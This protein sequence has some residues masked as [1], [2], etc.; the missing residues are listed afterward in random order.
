MFDC[1]LC[2]LGCNGN[3]D[4]LI[5]NKRNVICILLYA[6]C[7]TGFGGFFLNAKGS[8]KALII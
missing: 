2:D 7:T 6:E 1:S 5:L 4:I 8:L 3:T